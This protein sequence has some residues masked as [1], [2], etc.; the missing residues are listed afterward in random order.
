MHTV[1]IVL[2]VVLGLVATLLGFDVFSTD[3]DPHIL[4]WL[5]AACTCFFAAHLVHD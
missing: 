1:L 5:G 4:G 2:A 3:G